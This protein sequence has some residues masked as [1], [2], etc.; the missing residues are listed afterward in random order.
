MPALRVH[1]AGSLP[2]RYLVFLRRLHPHLRRVSLNAGL[3]KPIVDM[4]A[5]PFGVAAAARGH[6]R[7]C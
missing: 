7:R 6:D 1:S 2:E 3:P 4:L 5:E